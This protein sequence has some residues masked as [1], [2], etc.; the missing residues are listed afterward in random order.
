MF[1]EEVRGHGPCPSINHGGAE[2]LTTCDDTYLRVDANVSEPHVERVMLMRRNYD[3]L[4][5]CHHQDRR[6]TAARVSN[7]AGLLGDTQL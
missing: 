1:I 3:V 6:V 7:G 4:K 5:T 2:M